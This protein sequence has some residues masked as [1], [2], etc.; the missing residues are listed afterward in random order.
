MVEINASIEIG[1]MVREKPKEHMEVLI[2][3]LNE[4]NFE[5]ACGS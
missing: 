2:K 4:S 1:K 5:S 3:K